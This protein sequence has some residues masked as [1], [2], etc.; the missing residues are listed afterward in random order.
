[1]CHRYRG[2]LSE[3]RVLTQAAHGQAYRWGQYVNVEP[4][5]NPSLVAPRARTGETLRFRDVFGVQHNLY[6]TTQTPGTPLA[7]LYDITSSSPTP[8]VLPE[9]MAARAGT[10]HS[11]A[12][13]THSLTFT[14]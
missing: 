7:D 3:C 1:M 13:A 9:P 4:S 5:P 6:A 12:I 14:S 8:I 11:L 2:P 10:R